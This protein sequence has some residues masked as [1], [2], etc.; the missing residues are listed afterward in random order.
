M[1]ICRYREKE[2]TEYKQEKLKSSDSCRRTN[3]IRNSAGTKTKNINIEERINLNKKNGKTF[4]RKK[5]RKEGKRWT[6][7]EKWISSIICYA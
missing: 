5:G 6:T 3:R 1:D 4:D 7:T 2:K